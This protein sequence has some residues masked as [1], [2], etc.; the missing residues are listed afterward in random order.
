MTCSV[1]SCRGSVLR[2]PS[3]KERDLLA[4]SLKIRLR[5][6]IEIP[7]ARGEGRKKKIFE[8]GG[9]LT[10]QTWLKLTRRNGKVEGKTSY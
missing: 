10:H 7:K 9:I 4:Q 1:I 8:I 2:S 5:P 6:L 3:W